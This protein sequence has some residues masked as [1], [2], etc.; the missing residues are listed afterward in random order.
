MHYPDFSSFTIDGGKVN[1]N[2][3]SSLYDSRKKILY[4]SS[5]KLIDMSKGGTITLSWKNA[6]DATNDK[7]SRGKETEEDTRKE[8]KKRDSEILEVLSLSNQ[9]SEGGGAGLLPEL[10]KMKWKRIEFI[11]EKNEKKIYNFYV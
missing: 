10:L 11:D 8:S 6:K 5:A 9:T 7:R 2:V 4:I 1:I 3:Q